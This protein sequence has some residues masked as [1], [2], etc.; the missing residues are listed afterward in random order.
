[1]S[2]ENRNNEKEWNANFRSE[3]YNIWPRSAIKNQCSLNRLEI[4]K[5]KKKRI[6]RQKD[7]LIKDI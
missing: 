6:T 5:K 2:E 1:M 4:I 3:K 7:R